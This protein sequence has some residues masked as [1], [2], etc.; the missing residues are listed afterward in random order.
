MEANTYDIK[1]VLT[2]DRRFVVP[3]FQRDYEWTRDGQWQLLFED[4]ETVA[5]R[6]DDARKGA[7]LRGE[8]LS[9]ADKRVPPH[10]LGAVV[11]DQLPSPA[12][13]LEVRS[14]IDGQQRLTTVQ[15]LL[16]GLLDVL[17]ERASP[18]A[19][20]VRRLVR[21]PADV[22]VDE[23][24]YFKLWPRRRDRAV[25]AAV[26][27]DAHDDH[28]SHLYGEARRFFRE[29]VAQA[30]PDADRLH[31]FVDAALSLFKIVV[32]DLEDN[33]D[34]QVIFE[35]LNGRQTALSASDLVKNLLFLRAEREGT[36]N[37]ERLYDRH[38]ARFDEP[39]WKVELGRGHATRGRRDVLLSTWLSGAT[40]VETN[41]GRLYGEVRAHLEESD[42]QI[43][44][45]LAEI[46]RYADAFRLVVEAEDTLAPALA[47]SYGRIDKLGVSTA[48]P[49]L[50][51]LRTL[52]SSSLS[53]QTHL[54]AVAAIES[55]IVRRMI[56][57]ANTRGYGKRFIDLIKVGQAART[58]NSDPGA[59]ICSALANSPTNIAWPTDEEVAKA[60]L[61]RPMYGNLSQARVRLILG[62]I[63][64]R[65][66]DDSKKGEKATF[67]YDELQIEHI[68]PQ[69]W[70][71]HWPVKVGD[72][73]AEQLRDAAID[74]LGN[75]TLVTKSLNPAMSNSH[76][77]TKRGALAEHSKLHLN[78]EVMTLEA[79]SEI[80]IAERSARLAVLANRIWPSKEAL[81]KS[82][83]LAA[84][85]PGK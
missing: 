20:Q 32:I 10:F 8:S 3:T 58:A 80:E 64:E 46:S 72:A 21:N 83:G 22:C 73:T 12:G 68:L 70:R 38:W 66:Q 78:R 85:G 49:T 1:T 15:L 41:I 69:S 57:G 36:E 28:E 16:R 40:A 82:V 60:F 50:V 11:L 31:L 17:D 26:M 6:L 63:D 39:W 30:A 37:I 34:A 29:S 67:E 43:P 7:V 55:W 79:W 56:V 48:L 24:E 59:A 61:H 77:K 71:E 27:A 47:T 45:V 44:A 19:S 65:L 54:A 52:E 84:P 75:L 74:V 9:K 35:V 5:D 53:R 62:A 81:L 2:L 33:D 18:R 14:V 4:L 51:W 76:W 25:W 42:R 13:R 23:D